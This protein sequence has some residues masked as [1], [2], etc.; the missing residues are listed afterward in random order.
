MRIKCGHDA[1]IYCV[2]EGIIEKSG[3]PYFCFKDLDENK[4]AGSIRIRVE[5]I[6]Y[7]LRRYREQIIARRKAATEIEKELTQYEC[8][9]R[10]ELAQRNG[11]EMI[12][13]D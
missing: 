10:E 3:T 2:I 6:D 9:L 1:P 13:A 8:R 7:F 5:T 12:A 4:P 11:S